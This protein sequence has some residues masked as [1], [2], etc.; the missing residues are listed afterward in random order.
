MVPANIVGTSLFHEELYESANAN[1]YWFIK[2]PVI[3]LV[4]ILTTRVL[5]GL[6][7]KREFMKHRIF[8]LGAG[9]RA[10]AVRQMAFHGSNETFVVAGTFDPG[11]PDQAGS[12]AAG[13][14]AAGIEAED[15]T[16]WLEVV[17]RA[18]CVGD[19][20]RDG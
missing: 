10:A 12:E 7:N 1:T 18:P 6:A 14:E 16:D 4:V 8:V 2:A 13:I 20:R 3:W 9:T 5:F 19:R 15:E 11:T 17:R